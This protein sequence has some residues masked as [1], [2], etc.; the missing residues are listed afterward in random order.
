MWLDTPMYLCVSILFLH[1]LNVIRSL[2]CLGVRYGDN[3]V[4]QLPLAEQ[5]DTTGKGRKVGLIHG[6]TAESIFLGDSG[7]P[8][9]LLQLPW[10]V[11]DPRVDRP[12]DAL[13]SGLIAAHFMRQSN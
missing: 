8:P 13:V 10:G 1:K 9:W 3:C 2:P 5:R 12:M 7:E 4:P 6:A 11:H